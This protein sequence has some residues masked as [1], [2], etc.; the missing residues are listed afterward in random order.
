M[1][2][3]S[4]NKR[5]VIYLYLVILNVVLSLHPQ[6]IRVLSK[7]LIFKILTHMQNKGF[8]KFIAILFA[9]VCL[10][11]LSFTY[12]T[13][14]VENK[15][16]E[17]AHNAETDRLV[18][19]LADDDVAH[20][21]FVYDSIAK[22]RKNYYLDSMANE[23]VYNIGIRK[24]TFKE[25]R[26]RELNLGLD[27]KGGMNVT[28]EV[29][30]VDIIRGLSQNNQNPIFQQALALAKEK[31]K[32]SQEDFV[33]LFGQSINEIDP[34]F[35]LGSIFMAEFKEQLD[36][37]STNDEVLAVIRTET[38]A[39]I[40]RTFNIL[41][42]RIDRFGVAQPNIQKLQ[43]AGRILVELPG[44]KEPARVR[45]LL[46]GTAQLEFFETYKFSEVQQFFGS[47][48]A[49]LVDILKA[50]NLLEDITEDSPLTEEGKAEGDETVVETTETE[51]AEAD[52]TELDLIEQI[53][54]DSATIDAGAR[55]EEFARNNPLYAYLT[56]NFFRDENGNV[57]AGQSATV[58]FAAIKD[59]AMVNSLLR[60]AKDV[61][62]RDMKLAWS[63]KE[64]QQ[65]PGQ[66]ELYALKLTRDGGAILGGDVIVDARQNYDQ[67]N[68][69]VVDMTMNSDGARSWKRI[70]GDNIG[71]Q[72]AIVLDGYV[73]SAPNVSDEIPTGRSQISGGFDIPEAQDLANILKA[74][75]LPAP[76]RIVEEAVVGPSL[77]KVAISDG[78]MSFIIAF[79]LVLLYM[80][81]YY[82]KAG[83][84]ADL[85]L[86][87]NILFIF[88][89]LAS[90]GAVL[91]LPGIAGI[92]LTLGMA[93]DANV[94]IYERIKEE[95]RAGKGMRLAINDGYKNAYSA[96]IDGNVTTLLTGIVLFTFGSGPVQGFATTLIIGIIS[97]LFSAI[98]IS[99]LVFNWYL[100]KN[101]TIV[102]GNKFTN[103]MLANANYNFLGMRKKAYIFSAIIIVLGVTSLA[104]RGLN[105]GVDFSGGRTYVIRFDQPVSPNALRN[106][107]NESLQQPEVKTF[108]PSS[109]VKITT[110]FEIDNDD[111]SVDSIVQ[112]KLFEGLK[113]FYLDQGLSYR[114]FTADT[115]EDKLIGILS[116]QKV[117]PT[118]ADD[119]RNR[120]YM[121]VLFA[122]IVIFIYI[123]IR[124]K[125]WQ[126]G[127]SGVIAL[128]HDSLI[129]ISLFS[130]FY[131]VLPFNLEIDQ[132]FIAAILTII[133]YSIN[134]TVII[135]DRIREYVGLHPKRKLE[136]NINYGLN[137]T[138][139]RT[140]NT[141]GTTLLVL[142][143]IFI[144][145]GEVIRGFTFALLAGILI[146]T[147]SS[148]FVASPIAYDLLT[149]GGKK[150]VEKITVKKGKK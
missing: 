29:S 37:N 128:A 103:N 94:I 7:L 136:D 105:F 79:V 95:V 39:A 148:L 120:A 146:G 90:M 127:L 76:A 60:K 143:I 129:T 133:G 35:S 124:F 38:E 6:K 51:V 20:T 121:A 117:G 50:D 142:L 119:I 34:N 134:D 145:G 10:F 61:L 132:A 115:E 52:S 58:G 93:V 9:L 49:K 73:Y 122:L 64:S 74:G 139:A 130:I 56:P 42:T 70:T 21:R 82:N 36:F 140:I 11:H 110:K 108:G 80:L 87:T 59:T 28:L 55:N 101:K 41:R 144:F 123:A 24:Y 8:I 23:V 65:I 83:W 66:H 48:N 67:S 15:A 16:D 12:V 131:N 25:V 106:A 13:S 97:S 26:E 31:Q 4:E 3:I 44:I 57:Q 14:R 17:Y 62:P 5:F 113:P 27:L 107:L 63:I 32:N 104:M 102:F 92:V 91:T 19:I 109:Q 45:K 84:V 2:L 75:K 86:L 18:E 78:L 89:V 99:R 118:I 137:S 71:N 40:D 100:S 138:L 30:V 114:N 77:G 112:S 53:Q 98:F 116:S 1:G 147:Y 68:R 72:V 46:Q 96:I 125:K 149:A 69:V 54:Q 22:S 85:A 126:Y 81:L 150:D 141:S 47:A 33:T 111:P 135:F 43:T 88:G